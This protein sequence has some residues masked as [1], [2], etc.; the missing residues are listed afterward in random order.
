MK[1]TN[2]VAINKHS[3]PI[4][5]S[6]SPQNTAALS[7]TTAQMHT[8][9]TVLIGYVLHSI[10]LHSNRCRHKLM[11]I[12]LQILKVVLV[13]RIR[14]L[15]SEAQATELIFLI[16]LYVIVGKFRLL[17]RKQVTSSVSFNTISNIAGGNGGDVNYTTTSVKGGKG[18]DS[19]AVNFAYGSSG[20]PV[21]HV[22]GNTI[23]TSGV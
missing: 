16:H 10:I 23:I 7:R 17:T 19:Y 8:V 13:Y 1:G 14:T 3:P 12:L 15:L 20:T 4:L 21:A 18:G 5:S 6:E 22:R 2:P 11:A 9:F